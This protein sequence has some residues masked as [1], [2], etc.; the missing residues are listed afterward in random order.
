MK[1]G[2]L[3][4][5]INNENLENIAR[6]LESKKSYPSYLA[7]VQAIHE[8]L[9]TSTEKGFDEEHHT[10]SLMGHFST[11]LA[12]YMLNAY[13][14]RVLVGNSTTA[15]SGLYDIK[16]ATQNKQSEARTGGDFALA[17]PTPDKTFKILLF[18]AKCAKRSGDGSSKVNVY[19]Y[20]GDK[21]LKPRGAE[22]PA[23]L[24][25]DA[26]NPSPEESN[27]SPEDIKK[28][29]SADLRLIDVMR[30]Y[31]NI[32]A[33]L[34]PRNSSDH[35][36]QLESLLRAEHL[37]RKNSKH[38]GPLLDQRHLSYYV[39]WNLRRTVRGKDYY[40][41]VPT[42]ETAGHVS[43]I[44]LS[45]WQ[46]EGLFDNG[47]LGEHASLTEARFSID[48]ST[49]DFADSFFAWMTKP[50]NGG[51]CIDM[52]AATEFIGSFADICPGVDFLLLN[53]S[54][55][56]SGGGLMLE[57][58]LRDASFQITTLMDRSALRVLNNAMTQAR[59]AVA[60]PQL[61]TNKGNTAR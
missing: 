34:P 55:D 27:H 50:R 46:K 15:L 44:L 6:K 17:F 49:Y 33:E 26:G 52:E 38:K 13:S 57:N 11:N 43:N 37:A 47:L 35:I 45:K 28:R 10:A 41:R 30:N 20:R 40:P 23:Q 3:G 8:M 32:D 39:V 60:T 2:K 7:I 12:W 53:N 61:T 22:V 1:I 24:P 5:G 25:D 42:I 56:D 4:Y 9:W 18:Q 16:W 54:D 36:H 51:I 14:S 19:R 31:R 21:P 29:R 58:A 48:T 59:D